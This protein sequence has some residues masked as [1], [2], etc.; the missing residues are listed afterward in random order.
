MQ[1][2]A[3][4]R[5]PSAQHLSPNEERE[6]NSRRPPAPNTHIQKARNRGGAP[7]RLPGRDRAAAH[8]SSG[9][10]VSSAS[11]A[12]NP[13]KDSG[14]ESEAPLPQEVRLVAPPTS[15]PPRHSRMGI[16]AFSWAQGHTDEQHTGPAPRRQGASTK[17]HSHCFGA[18]ENFHTR[19]RA[20]HAAGRRGSERGT[21]CLSGELLQLHGWDGAHVL[22]PA[23]RG[24]PRSGHR[25]P[26]GSPAATP[27][28]RA[29]NFH[30]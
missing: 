17:L 3:L 14:T 12:A 9:H 24:G 7:G 30:S 21:G 20:G 25:D 10:Y 27:E 8:G 19:S 11:P 26:V 23:G 2:T 5:Q 13:H 29:V 4:A 6:Q 18:S 1:R 28:S 15:H 16:Q 22:K